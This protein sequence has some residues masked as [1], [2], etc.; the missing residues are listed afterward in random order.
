M[1]AGIFSLLLFF[2]TAFCFGQE[3]VKDTVKNGIVNETETDSITFNYELEDLVIS[4]VNDE[5]S[6]D[7]KKRLLI[8][9][10]RV[11]KVYPYAKI[12]ADRL[13]LLNANMAKLKT[14]KEK[15]KY[16]KIVEKYLEDEFEA[17]LKKLS[18]KDG[19][20]L[21]KLIHRQTGES[22]FDLIKE[23]KSGWKAFWSN[24]MAKLFDIDIKRKY[25]PATVPEDYYIE[26]YL[27]EAFDAHRLARQEPAFEIDY[28]AISEM[29]REKNKKDN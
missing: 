4:N 14:D 2:G 20:I 5:L 29:W 6:A 13:T 11:L 28:E 17:Q 7:E 8:L 25:S 19:Q 21:V 15:K 22:T 27:L 23:H 18:R 9:K 16:S 12:A 10:R 24:R 1:K 3:V 26:G